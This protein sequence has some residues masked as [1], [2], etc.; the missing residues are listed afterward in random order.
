MFDSLRDFFGSQDLF[1]PSENQNEL[2]TEYFCW[3]E[4]PANYRILFDASIYER[5]L[6]GVNQELGRRAYWDLKS[7]VKKLLKKRQS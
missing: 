5:S 7:E 6:D 3:L 2:V 4:Q 1:V